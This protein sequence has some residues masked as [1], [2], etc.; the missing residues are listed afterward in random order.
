MGANEVTIH[1]TGS[2]FGCLKWVSKTVRFTKNKYLD[3]AIQLDGRVRWF[4][5]NHGW[6]I[7]GCPS[8][9]G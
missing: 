1:E 9:F 4:V 8:A 7:F 2:Y 5:E 3:R 6:N